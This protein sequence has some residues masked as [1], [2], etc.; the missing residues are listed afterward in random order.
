MLEL[1]QI[2]CGEQSL[3]LLGVFGSEHRTECESLA[4][5]GIVGDC[6]RIGIRVVADGVDARPCA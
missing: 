1:E 6:Y 3:V 2:L 5:V 4:R